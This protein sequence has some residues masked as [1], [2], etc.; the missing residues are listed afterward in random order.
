MICLL[1]FCKISCSLCSFYHP[2]YMYIGCICIHHWRTVLDII[3]WILPL[4]FMFMAQKSKEW[5]HALRSGITKAHVSYLWSL[6]IW[7]ASNIT[8]ASV[9][10]GTRRIKDVKR[11]PDYSGWNRESGAVLA[12]LVH[13]LPHSEFSDQE[14]VNDRIDRPVRKLCNLFNLLNP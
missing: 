1:I 7:L 10:L 13:P 4:G 9:V 12:L 8:K 6:C 2:V 11:L 14:S 5:G 3:L